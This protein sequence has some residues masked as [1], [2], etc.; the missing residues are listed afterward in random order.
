MTRTIDG[1]QYEVK[2]TSEYPCELCD[3]YDACLV[4]KRK[5]KKYPRPCKGLHYVCYLKEVSNENYHL[6]G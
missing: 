3:F 5:L 4:T 6:Y 2:Y 1:K